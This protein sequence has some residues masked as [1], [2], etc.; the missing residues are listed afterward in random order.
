MQ[1]FAARAAVLALVLTPLLAVSAVARDNAEGLAGETNDKV[2]TFFS[3]GVLIFFALVVILGSAIQSKLD[4]R[5]EEKK[6]A[7]L[8]QRTGW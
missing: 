5:K 1:R 8:R 3:L 6:A 7:A 4:R 2:V